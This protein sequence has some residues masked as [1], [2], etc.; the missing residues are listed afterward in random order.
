MPI[1]YIDSSDDP[2]L[3]TWMG[4]LLRA[5]AQSSSPAGTILTS[6]E[7]RETVAREDPGLLAI[8]DE[9]KQKFDSEREALL[10]CQA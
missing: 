1:L 5:V 9:I 7:I 4:N 10:S 2:E 8:A 3:E 6:D